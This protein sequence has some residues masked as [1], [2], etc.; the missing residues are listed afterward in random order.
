MR[1]GVTAKAEEIIITPRLYERRARRMAARSE[2]AALH[3]LSSL[4]AA[5]PVGAIQRLLELVLKLCPSA[6]SAGLSELVSNDNDQAVFK[7]T[8]T[9]GA[10]GS[11]IGQATPRDLSPASLC[12]DHRSTIL[13]ERPERAFPQFLAAAP[14]V[15]EALLVP[16]YGG[17]RFPIAAL[18]AMSHDRNAGFDQTDV[19]I[20]DQLAV[21]LELALKLR[22]PAGPAVSPEK[23]A[24]ARMAA[25]LAGRDPDQHVRIKLGDQLIFDDVAWRYPDFLRCADAAYLALLSPPPPDES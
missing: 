22:G 10:F 15:H 13:I 24:L 19:R 18:W 14:A 23:E 25:R 20:M 12:L 16:L 5:D 4:M 3:E 9:A 1:Q 17:A 2:L 6:G 21:Q 11:C 8:A 7:R